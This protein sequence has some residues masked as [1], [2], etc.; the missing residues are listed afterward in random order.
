MYDKL[1]LS[2]DKIALS[3]QAFS[4]FTLFG[5]AKKNNK[6][7][8]YKRYINNVS[9]K[10]DYEQPDAEH[11]SSEKYRIVL[12]LLR[13]NEYNKSKLLVEGN[14]RKWY[15]GKHNIRDLNKKDFCLSVRMLAKTIGIEENLLWN[16]SVTKLETGVTLK[17]KEEHRGIVN[18]IFDYKAFRKNTYDNSGVEFKGENY[19]VIFYDMLRRV[20]NQ[21]NKLERTYKKLTKKNFLFRYEIQGHKVSG[22]DMFKGKANTLLKLKT[23]WKYIGTNLINTLNQVKF[24]NTISPMIYLDI[25]GGN[26]TQMTNYLTYKGIESIGLENFRQLIEQMNPKKRSEYKKAFLLIHDEHLRKDKENYKSVFTRKLQDKI[27]SL[28]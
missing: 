23:N 25:K 24:V 11:T 18:C 6:I 17:L 5:R 8:V 15:Y 21:K 10:Q 28:N 1:K 9:V 22:M 26:K 14:L 13:D 12:T 16:A 20:F 2:L 3:E 19:D 7:E 27:D 4:S